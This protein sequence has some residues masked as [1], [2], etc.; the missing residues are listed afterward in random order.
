M[1]SSTS[2]NDKL[3]TTLATI[4]IVCLWWIVSFFYP[5]IILPSPAETFIKAYNLLISGS[6]IQDLTVTVQRVLIAFTISLLGGTVIGSLVGKTKN[7]YL[8]VKPMITIIQTV[9]PIA[10]II[11]AIIWLGLGGGVPI[12]VVII[13]TF[14]IFFLNAAQ[15]MR[16]VSED[17]LEMSTIFRIKHHRVILDV[18]FPSLWPFISSAI[19]ICIGV[20]WKTIVMAEL[21][22]SNSGV[23]AA[24]GLARL[25]LET[26]EVLAW[27]LT[28]VTLGVT[29]EQIFQYFS[30]QTR[31]GK[32]SKRWK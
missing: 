10:W 30:D 7:I 8:F 27:T 23:G 5:P 21:L 20:S 2:Q 15:G 31:V 4:F 19:T 1:K 3:L 28:V 22:S 29:C 6:L 17:L 14:P 13:A 25:Q 11:L 26:A 18:Y 12:F 16:Q 24:L 9:P 32:V